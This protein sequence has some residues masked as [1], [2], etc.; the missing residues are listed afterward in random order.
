MRLVITRRY[1]VKSSQ[2]NRLASSLKLQQTCTK[3]LSYLLN[4]PPRHRLAKSADFSLATTGE[5][6]Y[7]WDRHI[8]E[9]I[10]PRKPPNIR[11]NRQHINADVLHQLLEPWL[12]NLDIVLNSTRRSFASLRMT[13]IRC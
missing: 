8:L 5:P 11:V 4:V 7:M 2:I 3:I 6:T 9:P 12:Y 1:S 13:G 10:L